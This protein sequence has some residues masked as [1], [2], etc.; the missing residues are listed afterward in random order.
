MR[1]DLWRLLTGLGIA[2]G[3]PWLFLV[4]GP[5]FRLTEEAPVMYGAEESSGF[6]GFPDPN[7]NRFGESDYGAELYGREGCAYCHTQ[8]IR[9]TYAGP[10]MW[11]VGW[12]G[13]EGEARETRPGDYAGEG[14]AYLGYQRIGP[15]LS[16]VGTRIADRL[17]KDE[18]GL[19]DRQWHH[20]HLYAPRQI[21]RYSAMP[22]FQHLYKK[23]PAAGR[24]SAEALPLK[25]EFAPEE[26]YVIVPTPEAEALVDY[27]LS[28]RKA[29]PLPAA[30]RPMVSAGTETA[31]EG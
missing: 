15:D 30:M 20:L 8:V 11:R 4:V 6:M 3:I 22:A 12:G 17:K 31:T 19:T 21:E 13:R 28:R 26:G 23:V 18:S 2:F 1:N 25:K 10:D 16:N 7:M 29:T 24:E 5:Y 14:Y 27:L 9:P